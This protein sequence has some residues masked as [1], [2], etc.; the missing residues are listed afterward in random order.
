MRTLPCRHAAAS[1]L[2]AAFGTVSVAAAETKPT[3]QQQIDQLQQQLQAQRTQLEAQQKLLEQQ[4]AVIEQLR[5]Q[6]QQSGEAAATAEKVQKLE[7]TVAQAKLKEQ[8]SARVSVT[9]GRPTITSADGRQ[10]ASLR[11]VVQLDMAHHQQDSAG[12][13]TTDFRRGSV[14]GTGNREINSAQDLSDGAYFRRAR[15]GFDGSVARDFDYRFMLELGGGGTEGPTRI[16]DAWI[17]YSGFAPFRIQLGAFS[18]AANMEDSTSVEDLLFLERATPAELSRTLAGADGRIGIAFRGNGARWMGSLTFT[19]RTVNDAE[20]FDSQLGTV[21]RAGFLAATGSTYDVH[22]GLS[23]SYVFR[24]ADQGSRYGVR[25]RDRP[26]VRVDGTRLI[27]T[28]EL[29]ADSAYTVG[30]E[31]GATWK[32]YLLQAEHYWYGVERPDLP[33][34]SFAAYYVQASWIVTGERHR[35]NLV[36]GAFQSPRPQREYGA[37]EL[38]LRYSH[39]DLDF[40]AG[41]PGTAAAS[42]SVRGGRQNVWTFGINW[43]VS[44]NVRLMLD[45]LRV[46][47]D[48]LNPAGVEDLAPFGSA[49]PPIGVQIGQDLDVIALRSQFNF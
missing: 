17:A 12:P 2:L 20:V 1:F 3:V 4:A 34:A 27:D 40:R 11:A 26:E 47:V 21:S 25:F 9:N 14:G 37:W 16:N 15:M 42:G 32:N 49:T 46:S 33:D 18:P 6:A 38:A 44:A 5:Q 23:G 7:Q 41:L 43:Y 29:R 28:G 24:F 10:S 39:T 48:R 45:Y 35:Y 30:T 13:L 19:G 36:N 22:V 8:E 31:F